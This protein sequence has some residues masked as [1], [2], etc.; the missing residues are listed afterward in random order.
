MS[1]MRYCVGGRLSF[2]QVTVPQKSA[3]RDLGEN[4]SSSVKSMRT[5]CIYS[6]NLRTETQ[7]DRNPA[8]YVLMLITYCVP[9]LS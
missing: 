4:E 9:G 5:A 6:R 3:L 7:L 1:P 8:Y 2:S